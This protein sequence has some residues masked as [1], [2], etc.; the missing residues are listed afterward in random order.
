MQDNRQDRGSAGPRAI[1]EWTMRLAGRSLG[2]RG[3]TE[4]ALITDWPAI[5]GPALA[6]G[7]LPLKIVFAG[8]ARSNGTLHVR[9]A[10][11]ALGLEI[12]HLEPLML[13]RVNG[14]FGYGAV[15]RLAISQGPV[16]PRPVRRLP[17]AP[18]LDPVAEQCVARQC[19]A[20]DDPDLRAALTAL[21]RRLA[22]RR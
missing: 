8:G 9:V 13:Q 4:T 10:N 22:A 11:G 19:A 20:V 7:T 12:Q 17:P 6:T 21:G 14:H 3:F 15:S 16:P 1:A 18:S 5:V 2:K